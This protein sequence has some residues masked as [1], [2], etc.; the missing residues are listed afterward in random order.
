MSVP[1]VY[2]IFLFFF[3]GI[4]VEAS[5]PIGQLSW[6][7][8]D[9]TTNC[10]TKQAAAVEAT[11]FLLANMPPWDEFNKVTLFGAPGGVDGLD[12]GIGSV[13]VN[14]SIDGKANFPWSEKIP[15]DIF[16]NH[17]LPY[18]SVNE[19]RSVFNRRNSLIQLKRSDELS[20]F[21]VNQSRQNPGGG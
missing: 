7:Q 1:V 20:E 10:E 15:K 5:C 17:V 21:L 2:L 4:G 8:P 12:S 16:L 9:G 6:P 18:A 14:M 13:T 19:A 3:L 11:N